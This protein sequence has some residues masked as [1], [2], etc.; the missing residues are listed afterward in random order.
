[1][2]VNPCEK[3]EKGRVRH[4]AYKTGSG[5]MHGAFNVFGPKG[6][7]LH[8]L[9]SGSGEHCDGWEHVSVSTTHRCPNWIEMC[10]VK[11]LF[12]KEDE[13]VIQYHPPSSVY[14]N[15]H[16]NCLHMWKPVGLE[17]PIPP[18]ILVGPAPQSGPDKTDEPK[19]D[20]A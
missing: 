2:K 7:L 3:L 20:V 11:D 19:E 5:C 12:W 1:M 10:M 18:M 8:I 15:Y 9:S 6:T 4:G 14:V 16:P 17:I 13:C